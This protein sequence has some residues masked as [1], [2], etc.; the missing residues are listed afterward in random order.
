[1]GIA[2]MPLGLSLTG[3]E[4]HAMKPQP[5]LIPNGNERPVVAHEFN[6]SRTQMFDDVNASLGNKTLYLTKT[7]DYQKLI[8]EM[9]V[10]ERHQTAARNTMYQPPGGGHD[11]LAVSLGYVVYVL[12][13]LAAMT[14]PVQRRDSAAPAISS[15]AWT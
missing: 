3:A 1:M 14:R 4:R 8:D 11:D 6:M 5:I 15:A 12:S 13:H 9:V 7:G 10:L 2:P